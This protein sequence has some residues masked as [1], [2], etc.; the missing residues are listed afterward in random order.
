MKDSYRFRYIQSRKGLRYN[1]LSQFEA[2]SGWIAVVIIGTLTAC[3]AFVVDVAEATISDWK[4]GYCTR[5]PLL[6]REACCEDKTPLFTSQ[7]ELADKCEHFQ[8]WTSS[9][10]GS[11]AIYVGMALVFGVVSSS[12]TM[13]T[14]TSLPAIA[15]EK[16]R[17]PN[18]AD[19]SS[20]SPPTGKVMYMASG[21]GI[22]E[23]AVSAP[24]HPMFR[25]TFSLESK[26]FFPVS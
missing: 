6:S 3:V 21:S 13:L 15:P 20:P 18:G 12:A 9:Y 2:C 24:L 11:F 16:D 22:P 23:Y 1:L 26:P 5:N 10:A 8:L 17:K 19:E 4:L 25:L 14:R 7:S